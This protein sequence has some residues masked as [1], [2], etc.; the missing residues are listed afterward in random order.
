MTPSVPAPNKVE[1]FLSVVYCDDVR[2][3]IH[4]K[5]S[6]VGIY[7]H[8]LLVPAFPARILRLCIVLQLF[9]PKNQPF[10]T[11]KF[12]VYRDDDLFAEIEVSPPQEQ[13]DGQEG[14]VGAVVPF[15]FENVE[16]T[17]NAKFRVRA[18]FDDGMIIP[19]PSLLVETMGE[20]NTNL[21]TPA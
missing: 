17:A 13:W 14:F 4:N 21:P 12:A 9:C 16:F 6:F 3:E 11:A 5:F 10:K 20:S 1:R 7:Q 18:I 8:K 15:I 19:A 2:S